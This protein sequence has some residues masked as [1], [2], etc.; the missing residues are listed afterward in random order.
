MHQAETVIKPSCTT[1][2]LGCCKHS[3]PDLWLMTESGT[4]RILPSAAPGTFIAA[5]VLTPSVISPR[6]H[7]DPFLFSLLYWHES[8]FKDIKEIREYRLAKDWE[9]A[10][11]NY[12]FN[13]AR[14]AA[15]IPTMHPTLQQSLYR[16]IK[17][18]IKVMADD[19]RRYDER[20][21]ASHEEAK[22]IMEYLK[23]H[24]RNIPL[25]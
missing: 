11:N 20:N 10:V 19:S 24:G 6:H 15:A 9:M 12:S 14:F 1:A 18:C 8:Y 21:M 7:P 23:E 16:L 3:G 5:P 22:C 4:G 25:K 17:E 13:P 2:A